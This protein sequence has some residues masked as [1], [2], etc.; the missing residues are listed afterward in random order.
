MEGEK[1]GGKGEN[2]TMKSKQGGAKEILKKTKGTR[3]EGQG[4][5]EVLAQLS[6]I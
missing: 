5:V 4:Y 1:G 3:K 6:C 2:K